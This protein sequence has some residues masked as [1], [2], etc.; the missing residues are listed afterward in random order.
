MS[1]DVISRVVFQRYSQS[2]TVDQL[3]GLV[4]VTRPSRMLLQSVHKVI[5]YRLY[6]VSFSKYSSVVFVV[7]IF[8]LQI[9]RIFCSQIVSSHRP[10]S[11]PEI[12]SNQR[13][14]FP[15]LLNASALSGEI[16]SIF[17]HVSL[18]VFPFSCFWGNDIQGKADRREEGTNRSKGGFSAY[19]F[20]KSQMCVQQLQ[21]QVQL[22]TINI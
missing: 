16:F 9:V 15:S 1:V 17:T 6:F 8:C 14:D 21:L 2:E 22:Q 12:S 3:Y 10:I 18:G 5:P 7:N 19:L 4:R 20:Y 11:F 13:F